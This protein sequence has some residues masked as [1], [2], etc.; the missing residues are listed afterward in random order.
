M[1]QNG[2][3]L[4]PGAEKYP[5]CPTPCPPL[6]FENGYFSGSTLFPRGI[7]RVPIINIS[8]YYYSCYYFHS[9]C[10]SMNRLRDCCTIRGNVLPHPVRKY[11][12]RCYTPPRPPRVLQPPPL[13]RSRLGG[14]EDQ[15]ERSSLYSSICASAFLQNGGLSFEGNAQIHKKVSLFLLWR[16]FPRC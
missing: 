8:C 9:V 11:A 16:T 4:P 5:F 1:G 7:R 12:R 14:L 13:G 2:Y 3:F 6:G 10:G 15:K